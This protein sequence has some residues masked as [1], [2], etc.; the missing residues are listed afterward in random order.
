MNKLV[1]IITPCY[2]GEQYLSCFLDSILAQTY[3]NIEL[4][5]INDG[6]SDK[7][8][9][10]ALS[11]TEKFKQRGYSYIY[12]H[13][14]NAGQSAAINKGLAVF[15]G[16]YMTWPDADDYFSNDAI[17]KKVKYL[18]ANSDIGMV[19]CKTQ[20]VDFETKAPLYIMQRNRPDTDDCLWRDLI[21]GHNVYYSPG[22]Y[23]VRS[24]MFRDAMPKPPVIQSPREIGQNYQLMIPVAYKHPYG[25]IDEVLYYY[26]VRKNSHS[27]EFKS[28]QQLLYKNK[29]ADSVLRSIAH[30]IEHDA[31]KRSRIIRVI[32]YKY[33]TRVLSLVENK[34]KLFRLFSL[35]LRHFLELYRKVFL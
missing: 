3:D 15:S 28:F 30:D 18:E 35:F 7:T 26:S 19:I 21:L 31:V 32:R 2:N 11:Y 23:M 20:A 17:E 13:Q 29:I 22:G 10:I 6:S 25:L 27:R 8:E 1:S 5:L 33:L 34:H 9:S 14:E 16:E 12:L 24:S 4:I